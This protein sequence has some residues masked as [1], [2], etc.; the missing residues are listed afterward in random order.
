LS[1]ASIIAGIVAAMAL[2]VLFVLLGAALGFAI[3]SPLTDPNPAANFGAGAAIV[4]GLSAV[5]SLWFGGWVAGRVSP[6]GVRTT[7]WLHGFL[8][9]CGA[10]V[11]G[12]L[13]VASGAG[14]AFSGVSKMVG[15]GLSTAGRPIAAAAGHANDAAKDA[16]QHSKATVSSFVDEAASNPGPNGTPAT[17]I[18]T[19]RDVGLAL[20]R[21]FDPA[22]KANMAENKAAASKV[23]VDDTG[24]SQA[25]AD[26]TVNEWSD[27]YERLQAEITDAKNQAEAKARVEADEASKTL[28]ILSGCAFVAFLI[29]AAASTAGASH[30]VLCARRQETACA[31]G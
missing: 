26:K 23:L 3:F 17:G 14:T 12:V 13:A 1:W 11:V 31:I 5:V 4:E 7:G 10:T 25:D 8:V 30:G 21:L 9:W 16:L 15:G 24:M 22:Q 27:T 29:G 19:R 28:S 18:R 2:E 6:I 20:G